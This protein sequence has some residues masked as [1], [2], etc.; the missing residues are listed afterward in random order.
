VAGWVR[1][2]AKGWKEMMDDEIYVWFGRRVLI[3]R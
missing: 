3:A 2:E 1:T